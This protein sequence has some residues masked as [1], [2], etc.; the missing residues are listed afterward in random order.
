MVTVGVEIAFLPFK[1]T[2]QYRPKFPEFS[3][4]GIIGE[5]PQKSVDI[6]EV[7][8]VVV[9]H[10]SAVGITADISIAIHLSSPL[11]LGSC[12]IQG[13]VLTGMGHCGGHIP[14]LTTCICLKMTV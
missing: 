6:I 4:I 1:M 5:V 9:H 3:L 11:F 12:H 2:F 10:V 8:V 14:H 7:H 13:T